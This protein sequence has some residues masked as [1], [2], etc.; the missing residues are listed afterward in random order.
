MRILLVDDDLGFTESN[1]NLLEANGYEV[2]T[3]TNGE[4]GLALAR[5]IRPDVMILDVMMV[6]EIEGFDVAR[7]LSEYPELRDMAVLM[8]TG[9]FSSLKIPGKLKPDEAWLPVDRILDKPVSPER[10]IRELKRVL[11]KRQGHNKEINDE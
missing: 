6:N 2:F 4:D 9:L 5:V 7:R 3:A 8:L 11:R 1:K 10:L